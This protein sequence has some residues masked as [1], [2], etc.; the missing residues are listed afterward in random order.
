[1]KALVAAKIAGQGTNIDGG[2][3]LSDLLN[4]IVDA[5]PEGGGGESLIVNGTVNSSQFQITSGVSTREILDA[6]KAGRTV[7]LH[8]VNLDDDV[9]DW[10]VVI[11]YE[12]A[13]G[14]IQ[15]KNWSLFE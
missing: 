6:F 9:D 13:V 8:G 4:A 12:Y 3:A 1:M 7:V 14:E 15:T 10:E 2:G 11:A 5:I